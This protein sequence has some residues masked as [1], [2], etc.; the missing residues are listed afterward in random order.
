MTRVLFLLTVSVLASC[1]PPLHLGYDFGRA[2]VETLRVQADL[3]RPSVQYAGYSLYGIEAV[4]IR[5][6]V[7]EATSD[8]EEANATLRS[9]GGGG[10]GGGGGGM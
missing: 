5:L 4:Q 7:N 1:K 6:N 2:Y 9:V 8:A 3:T 10:G